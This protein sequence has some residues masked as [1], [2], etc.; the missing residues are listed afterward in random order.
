MDAGDGTEEEGTNAFEVGVYGGGTGVDDTAG[1]FD[2][3][4]GTSCSGTSASIV[5]SED[6]FA[7]VSLNNGA[8]GSTRACAV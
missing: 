5:R 3:G 1:A 2:F 6:M 8:A 7:G 4:S